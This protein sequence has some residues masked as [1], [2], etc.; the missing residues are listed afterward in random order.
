MRKNELIKKLTVSASA[1]CLCA[2]FVL[3]APAAA[4]SAH[5]M[6]LPGI[7]TYKDNISYV[8][9]IEDN[10]LYKCLYNYTSG[11]YIGDWIYVRDL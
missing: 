6:T 9:K 10:K 4:I 7:S 8:Y 11:N 5:A 3:T 2:A 1:L